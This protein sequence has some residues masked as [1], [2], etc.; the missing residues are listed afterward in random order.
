MGVNYAPDVSAMNL[1]SYKM[2]IV[3]YDVNVFES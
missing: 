3:S 1:K 2:D